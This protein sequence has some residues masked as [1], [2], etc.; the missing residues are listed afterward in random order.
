MDIG[1]RI[2]SKIIRRINYTQ[3][4]Q[5]DWGLWNKLIRWLTNLKWSA[6][7]LLK[8]LN[9]TLEFI[10]PIKVIQNIS[11]YFHNLSYFNNCVVCYSVGGPSWRISYRQLIFIIRPLEDWI[12]FINWLVCWYAYKLSS[13]CY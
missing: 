6:R 4:V 11:L 10:N 3:A 13:R 7:F 2:N 8:N 9:N 1:R 12:K 5:R